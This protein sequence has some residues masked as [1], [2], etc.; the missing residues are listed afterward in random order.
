MKTEYKHY[1]LDVYEIEG[2]EYI[3][4]S[5]K[6]CMEAA[7]EYI[8]ESLWAFTSSFIGEFLNLNVRQVKALEKMNASLCEDANDI[9]LALIGSR[10]DEFIEEAIAADGIGHFL[11]TYDGVELDSSDVNGL[12]EGKLAFRIN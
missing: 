3:V 11:S 7:G 12:P 1:G 4:G 9:M 2:K 10:I 5:M 8:K 6:E